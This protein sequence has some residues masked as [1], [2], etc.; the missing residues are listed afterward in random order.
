MHCIDEVVYTGYRIVVLPGHKHND[1][2]TH[3][4]SLAQPRSTWGTHLYQKEKCNV[5][6]ME[7]LKCDVA[8]PICLVLF[9]LSSKGHTLCDVANNGWFDFDGLDVN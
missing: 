2:L 7:A 1:S 9:P 4:S 6:R 8:R 3:M 5:S